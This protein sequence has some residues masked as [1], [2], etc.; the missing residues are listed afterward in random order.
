MIVRVFSIRYLQLESPVFFLQY[1]FG[2]VDGLEPGDEIPH[3]AGTEHF[4]SS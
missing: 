3:A 1:L 2:F 4:Y